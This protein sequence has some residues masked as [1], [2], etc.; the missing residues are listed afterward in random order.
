MRL[1]WP[2]YLLHTPNVAHQYIKRPQGTTSWCPSG[3]ELLS[4]NG[5]PDNC[6]HVQDPVANACRC[7]RMAD[8][9]TKLHHLRAE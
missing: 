4:R 9:V 2:Q 3:D 6:D 7:F 1:L 5:G 8:I